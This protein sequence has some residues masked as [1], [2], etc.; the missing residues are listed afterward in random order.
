MAKRRPESR[1]CSGRVIWRQVPSL[2]PRWGSPPTRRGVRAP[3][4]ESRTCPGRVIWRRFAAL[5]PRRGSAPTR[6]GVRAPDPESRACSGRVI[7][8]RLPGL[9]PRRGP[10][11]QVGESAPRTRS[12]ELAR[13]VRCGARSKAWRHDGVRPD[14][15]G[16][17]RPG[18]GVPDLSG[19]VWF[20][21]GFRA[22]RHG[23]V[24]PDT[25]GSPR[26]EPGAPGLLGPCAVA[27]AS[28]L[29]AT[30]GSAPT[31]RGLRVCPLRHARDSRLR[32]TP[33][34]VA[35]V[36]NVPA[37]GSYFSAIPTTRK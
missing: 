8:R 1:A 10:P 21:A 25:S 28:G 11:R 6:R 30:M 9:A 18:P 4:P 27:P 37:A 35:R 26:P 17:P 24:R 16:S 14:K 31:S 22:W 19:A 15:S 7:W 5:A 3:N 2:A 33:S 36:L 29:G 13:A 32:Y 34:K 20:G 23:G 12:P